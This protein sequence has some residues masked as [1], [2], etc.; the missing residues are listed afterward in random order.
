MKI[1]LKLSTGLAGL[2]LMMGAT[3]A[4]A[5]S[6]S[7]ESDLISRGH[8][9]AVAADCAACHT[10]SADKPMA[11]GLAIASPFGQIYSSNISPSK[12]YGIGNYSEQQ[13]ARALREGVNAQGEWLYPAM[14]YPSYA[15][16][17]DADVSALYAY[18]MH[19]VK[20][21]EVASTPTQLSFPFNQRWLMFGWNMLFANGKPLKPDVTKSAEW[22]RGRYLVDALGHCDACHTPRNIAM[23]EDNSQMLAGGQLG[24]WFAPN[25]TSDSVSGIGGWSHDEL[26]TYLR[27][28]AAVGKGQAAGGMAEAVEK[29]LQY[30]SESDL[31]AIATY[32][33]E[34][35]PIR[36]AKD[37]Q[38]AYSFGGTG[39][40][41]EAA[42]RANNPGIEY[43][44]S[45][46][47]Y[48]QLTDGSQLYSANCA[49][50]HQPDGKGTADNAYP[51]LIHNSALGR[52]NADNLVAVI[53]NGI[54]INTQ[55]H[56]RLMPGVGD[57]LSDDQVAKLA[58]YVM[59]SFG[60]PAIKVSAEQVTTLRAG[61]SSPMNML[62]AMMAAGGT[63]VVV[64]VL[65]VWMYRRRKSARR[66]RQ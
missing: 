30:L 66:Q 24:A 56:G 2:A 61:G 13:F 32:L 59:Q 38:P 55:G 16:L 43:H 47:G 5:A 29:S 42:L 58:T 3:S 8:Y 15:G 26:V 4:L 52:D 60:N 48:A 6:T 37:T 53:I 62:Y 22:N 1:N 31:S 57:T 11:G 39:E 33:K 41:A 21:V 46:P 25:I 12:Q 18:F 9:L 36:N 34:T 28:G 10:V 65:A 20:P 49:S 17:S 63:L 19:G 35:P 7:A 44:K 64:V 23:G 40:N 51:S 54:N 27:T 50:C 14:P 45:Q